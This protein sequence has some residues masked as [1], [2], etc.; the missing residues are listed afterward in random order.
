MPDSLTVCDRNAGLEPDPASGTV[1]ERSCERL[2]HRA[3]ALARLRRCESGDRS[4]GHCD[5][6]SPSL[7]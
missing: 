7:A 4:G 1:V 5:R 3:G 2:C 6:P